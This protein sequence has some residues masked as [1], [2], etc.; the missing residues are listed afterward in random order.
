[1][2]ITQLAILAMAMFLGMGTLAQAALIDRGA[3]TLG[4]H[5]IYD[6]DL[7]IT[8]YDAPAVQRNWS[9]S[10]TWAASLTV[11]NTTAG[12]W[13]LPT[14]LYQDG[15]VPSM[16]YIGFNFTSSEM[17]HLYYVELENAAGGPLTNTSPFTNL[18]PGWYYSSSYSSAGLPFVCFFGDGYQGHT[19]A[20][21]SNYALPVH[22]GNVPEPA[23]IGL[24]SLGALSLLRR[25][26]SKA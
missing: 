19:Y 1:M 10:M 4:N 20:F 9:N 14:T 8:W 18:L 21:N 26:R 17:G 24:L 25:K 13:R 22:S 23:T 6:T 12:T 2:S 3:D 7:N 15:T 11:G 16:G 5:L